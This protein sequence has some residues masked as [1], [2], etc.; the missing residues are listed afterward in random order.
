MS[1]SS[2]VFLIIL[3]IFAVFGFGFI[4]GIKVSENITYEHYCAYQEAEYEYVQRKHSCI[5]D[6]KIEIIQWAELKT[7]EM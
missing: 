1:D 6:N 7:E 4:T 5:K 3:L 2:I